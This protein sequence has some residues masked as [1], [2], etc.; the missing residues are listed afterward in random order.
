MKTNKVYLVGAGPHFSLITVRGMEVLRQADVVIY[1]YLVD[2]R[3][4]DKTQDNAELISC[5]DLGKKSYSDGFP[6]SQKG[7][8]ALM[9]KKAKEGKRVVRL[10]NGDPAI[11][12]R[13]SQEI[14]ALAGNKIDFEII[15][16]VT[17][18]SAAACIAGIPL[19]DRKL[20]SSIVFVTGHEDGSKHKSA[21]NWKSIAGCGTIVMY[22]AVESISEIAHKLLKAGKEANTPVMAVSC[23]GRVNQKTI[24]AKLSTVAAVVKREKLSAPA[25][26]I[27]GKVAD[28]EK[29]A[30]AKK[31][32]R[33]LFTG[34]SEERFFG[35]KT[36]FHLPLIKIVPIDDYAEFDSHLKSINIFDWLVFTSR[37]GVE[38]FFKR[39]DVLDFDSRT[40]KDVKIAAIGGSTKRRLKDFG[41]IADLV[42]QN[43]SSS[44]LLEEFSKIDVSE[45]KI[46]LPR[47]DLSDKG[48]TEGLKEKG[49]EVTASVAYRNIEPG[50]L[51]DLELSGFDEIIF[52]S[53]S[54]ARNFVKKY[55]NKIPKKVKITC[56]GDVTLRE[57]KKC[58]LL[59]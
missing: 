1:D 2:R 55:G 5:A 48:L 13:T 27:I 4:L 54:G 49:A 33:A 51:P 47:S 15:P 35:E 53:P 26:F 11:F 30:R 43:E 58:G 37:Y 57:A 22:M 31:N 7:I 36:Y 50:D 9:V 17:A 21:V 34:L 10:K 46:F 20:S 42:P 6:D 19:T 45:K 14:D 3:L 23:A 18:A 28:F 25:I 32:K 59:D 39:M 16:G 24:K 38:Y 29:I 52:T 8:N 44:G 56:I 12:A 41:L 40:L